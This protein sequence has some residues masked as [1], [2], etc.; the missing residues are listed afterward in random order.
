MGR[1]GPSTF[2]LDRFTDTLFYLIAALL[3][4]GGREI[5]LTLLMP[6]AV[7]N[8][9]TSVFIPTLILAYHGFNAR[10]VGPRWLRSPLATALAAWAIGGLVYLA[11]HVHYGPRPR[12]EESYWGT[13]MVLHSL[14]MP[15]QI[16]FFFAAINLLPVLAL[17]SLKQAEP[18]L[19]RLFWL[20]VPLWFAIHIWA[21]RLGEGIMYLAPMTVI[22]VPL[23]LQGLETR[24]KSAE[25]AV[26]SAVGAAVP[27]PPG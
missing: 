4:L 16:T 1:I 6:L 20:V 12:V 18:F 3:V 17:L 11:I 5:W 25:L 7:A 21:A 27:H 2:S 24:L 23:V 14:H 13:A 15:D 9:E 19:R 26:P 8:R 10:L 22:V